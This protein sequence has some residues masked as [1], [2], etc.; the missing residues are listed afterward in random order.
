VKRFLRRAVRLFRRPGRSPLDSV[1]D[2][3]QYI[4]RTYGSAQRRP[5]DEG[6]RL[7]DQYHRGWRVR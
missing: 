6:G 7:D 2:G 1:Q 4:I 3:A 5:Y